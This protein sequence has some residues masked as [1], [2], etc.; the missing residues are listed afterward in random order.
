M[1]D[2]EKAACSLV[3]E[4]RVKIGEKVIEKPGTLVSSN[5][6]IKIIPEIDAEL[7]KAVLEACKKNKI[8]ISTA[9]LHR[10]IQN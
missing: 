10:Q 2:T 3:L 9:L 4:G 8:D 6:E 5:S 1:V 7:Y